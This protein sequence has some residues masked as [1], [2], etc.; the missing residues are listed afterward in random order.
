M[1]RERTGVLAR[2][3]PRG[4]LR[5]QLL[6]RSL[7]V[8]SVLL[9]LI[10][11]FQYVL[12]QQFLYR[13]KAVSTQTQLL[14]QGREL[15][16]FAG[17]GPPRRDGNGRAPIFMADASIALIDVGAQSFDVISKPPGVV[18]DPPQLPMETYGEAVNLRPGMLYFR[19]V[20]DNGGHKQL[21]VLQPIGIHGAQ[22]QLIA[23][24]AVDLRTLQ[25]VLIRQTLIFIVLSL[26]ALVIGLLTFL[27]VLK[28]TL[29]P[30]SNMVRTVRRI[31]AGSL[32]ERF[33]ATQGQVEI[34]QLAHSFNGMLERLEASFEAEKEAKEQMRR[35]IADASHELRTP[36]T[37]IH[38][39][40]EVLL[41][42]AANNPEQLHRALKSMYG[43]SERINKLVQDLLLLAKLDR[44]PTIRLEEGALD[45]VIRDM[46][47]QLRLLAG[48]RRVTFEL[49]PNVNGR[50]D[51][52][53]MKQLV[54]NLFHNAV[55]HTDAAGGRIDILLR[56]S[57]D[58]MELVISD[59]G[60]GIP[61]EHLPH[62]FERFYRVDTSRVRKSG[63]AGLG[64]SISLSIVEL[65]GG[66]IG[67]R[68][69][70]G[71][72]TMFTVQL[73]R[74]PAVAEDSLDL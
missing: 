60:H 24:A 44:S 1:M 37:S 63:G 51:T 68:S 22:R 25:V 73:P 26:V 57:G 14:S 67:V 54:L 50:F 10:G 4:S 12:M 47:P 35:F 74:N 20:G 27:P 62:L 39:F 66:T 34:D 42:G 16:F 5:L 9:L 23:E 38:G 64:L 32:N 8:M 29:V 36:L 3:L 6:S 71:R 46:E 48:E 41:R 55:Q 13:N 17:G 21:V 43:E 2:M 28:K 31:D 30:L 33:P 61:S 70:E 53:K 72:G 49:E 59:N 69:E 7:L 19:I 65:H 40:L 18:L 58:A 52:D 15:G 11:I 56:N 45:A